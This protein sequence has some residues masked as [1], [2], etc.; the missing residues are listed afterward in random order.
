MAICCKLNLQFSSPLLHI[1]VL[2]TSL[3][4]KFISFSNTNNKAMR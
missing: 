4:V 2:G 3:L 1:G